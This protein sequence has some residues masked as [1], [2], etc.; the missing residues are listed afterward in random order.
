MTTHLINNNG[1]SVCEVGKENYTTSIAGAF[2]GTEYYQYDYRHTNGEL[3]TCIGKSLE[4][5]R[6]KREVWLAENAND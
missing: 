6:Q 1:C 3:F 5:C 2:R 4:E